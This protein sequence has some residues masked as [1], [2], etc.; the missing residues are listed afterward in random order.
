[1]GVVASTLHQKI[2]FP[3]EDRVVVVQVY[4]NVAR[5]C[6]VV[7]INHEIKQ[8]EQVDWEQL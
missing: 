6:L 7:A 8:K 1:M 4:Q 2:K 3:T 5:Q